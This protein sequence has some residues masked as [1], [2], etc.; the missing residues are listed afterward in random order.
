MN[1]GIITIAVKNPYYGRMAYNLAASVRASDPAFQ[2]AL[3]ADTNGIAHLSSRQLEIFSSIIDV[4]T[5][6]HGVS[7]KLAL[8]DLSPFDET[9]FIDSDAIWVPKKSPADMIKT[10]P[11]DCFFT[12]ITEG[13]YNFET[14]E[15]DASPKYTFWAEPDDIAAAYNIEKGILYQFRSEIMFFRKTDRAREF[16]EKAKE[17]YLSPP[18]K[19]FE[20]VKGVPDELAFNVAACLLDIHPHLFRWRPS[21]WT[22]LHGAR[23]PQT[24]ILSD[25]GY[26]AVSCG[27]SGAQVPL[28]NF[29]NRLMRFVMSKIKRQHMF[30]LMPKRDFIKERKTF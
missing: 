27:G 25:N 11:D 14:K 18:E 28:K 21:F 1:Q 23:I 9:I 13:K 24:G 19:F 29:Y 4:D 6:D 7:L 26:F 3:I 17:I 30:E 20:F 5:V 12:A 2:F 16:F 22:G 10:I 8:F 15:K